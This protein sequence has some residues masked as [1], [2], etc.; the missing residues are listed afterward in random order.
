ML[1][2]P[3]VRY[4]LHQAGNGAAGSRGKHDGI[5]PI[6]AAP[7][8]LQRGYG[9]GSFLAG[10][11]EWLDLSSGVVPRLWGERRYVPEAIS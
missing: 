5:G 3:L 6:Y 1:M 4:Y 9:T 8:F 2:D 10:Y 11:G 7:L